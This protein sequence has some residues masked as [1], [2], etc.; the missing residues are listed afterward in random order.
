MAKIV[1]AEAKAQ[2]E[3]LKAAIKE[4]KKLQV[5]QK[6]SG[7]E[8][9][10]ALAKHTKA[11]KL[12]QKAAAEFAKAKAVYE[13]AQAELKTATERLENARNRAKQ[14]TQEI[15]EK[16]LEVLQ[17]TEQKKTDDRERAAQ[18]TALGR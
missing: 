13:T 1:K 4:L 8:E 14:T 18:L 10:D 11:V 7:K 15:K 17:A 6:T 12:D 16:N 3:T 5:V 9:S 2:D